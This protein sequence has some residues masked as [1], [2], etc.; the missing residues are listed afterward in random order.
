MTTEQKIRD[1]LSSALKTRGKQAEI[2]KAL[3]VHPSTVKRWAEGSEITPP[4]V[5]LLDWY[6]FGTVPHRIASIHP[7]ASTLNFDEGEWAVIGALARREGV[8][9]AAWI[10]ARIRSY[11]AYVDLPPVSALRVAEDFGGRMAGNGTE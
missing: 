2:S 1:A 9:E 10:A 11:L 5:T 7:S 8:T 6:F 3:N 4:V